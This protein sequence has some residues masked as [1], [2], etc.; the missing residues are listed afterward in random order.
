MNGVNGVGGSGSGVG[1]DADVQQIGRA[2]VQD[3]GDS[4]TVNL[5][6][7]ISDDGAAYSSAGAASSMG[8]G[9]NNGMDMEGMSGIGNNN[10]LVNPLQNKQQNN[11]LNG[12]G[13][14]GNGNNMLG[15]LANGVMGMANNL[16]SSAVTAVSSTM[17]MAGGGN[18]Q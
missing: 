3:N 15:N 10:N 13:Q 6:E 11:L 14:Q 9:S 17:G 7:F 8:S 1:D 18:A 4:V 16:M 12:L 5:G 2:S